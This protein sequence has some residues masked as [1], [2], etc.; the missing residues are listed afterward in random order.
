[1]AITRPGTD[2][3]DFVDIVTFDAFATTCGECL[4]KGGDVAVVGRLHL[5]EWT[6]REGECRSRLQVV[7]GA[8]QLAT[9]GAS[10]QGVMALR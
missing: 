8:V 4:T 7:A 1:V 2:G 3:A 6:S 9:M 10:L 5:K